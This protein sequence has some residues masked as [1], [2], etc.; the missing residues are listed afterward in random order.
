MFIIYKSNKLDVL[1]SK[2]CQIIQKKPLSN[3]FEKEIFIHDSKILFQYLNVFFAN[4]IGISTN[5]KL[6]HPKNFIWKIFEK[7]LYK[8]K[9]K[10]RFTKSSITWDIMNILNNKNFFKYIRKKDNISKK[11][12]FSYLMANI[13]EKY[14]IYRPNWINEWE[15]NEKRLFIDKNERWQIKLWQEIKNHRKKNHQSIYH[16]SNL[17]NKFQSLE[18]EK[19]IQKKDFPNRFFIISSFALNPSYIKI[20]KI[21]SQYT[22]IYF[23]Y[24]TPFKKNIFHFDLIQN[25]NILSKEKTRKENILNHTI[26]SL[27]GKYEEYYILKI[28]YSKKTKKI[29]Y[30]QKTENT[31]LL[32]NIKNNFLEFNSLKNNK[33]KRK[34]LSLT[35]DSISIN[36]C[37]NIHNEIEI[38]YEKLLIFFNKNKNLKPNDIVV[39]CYSITKYVSSINSIF[40][41]K[42]IKEN[43]PFFISTK[44]SKKT[45]IILLFFNKILDLPNSRFENEEILEFFDIPEV[46]NNFNISEEDINI[47]YYW[48][49]EANIR[50]GIDC[51][52]KKK[53]FF[54]EN[55][56][57]TWSWGI[58]K[59][60]LSYATNHTKGIWN[61]VLSCSIINGSRAELIGKLIIFINTLK[62]WQKK[63]SKL[64]YPSSWRSLFKDLIKD[65][66]EKKNRIT[67]DIQILYKNWIE[68]IDDISSCNYNNKISIKILKKNFTRKINYKNQK[69]LPGVINFCHPYDVCYI[70]FKIIC[71]IGADS[72]N[73]PKKNNVDS[74]INLLHKYPCMGDTDVYEKYCYLFLQSISCT[75]RYFY[76]SYVGYSIK[77]ES[78]IH[79]SIL[80]DQLLNYITLNFFIFNSHRLNIEDN[81][82]KITNHLC[83]T[84]KKQY[85]YRKKKIKNTQDVFKNIIIKK[86][87]N[88]ICNKKLSKNNFFNPITL[89]DLIYFWKNP[90][91]YFFNNYLKIN[92]ISKKEKINNTEP[93]SVKK[94]DSFRIKKILLNKIIKKQDIKEFL[95]YYTLSGKLP[96]GFFG[97]CFLNKIKTEMES[98]AKLVIKYK[99]LTKEKKIDLTLKK[100]RINGVLDEIQ[101]N[102]LLRW[103]PNAI[104]YSDRIGL[105]I[106]H[107]VYSLIEGFG[108]SKIIGYKNQI[109]SFS[110]LDPQTAYNYLYQYIQGYI[111]GSKEIILLTKSGSSWL[112]QVYDIKNNF[113][114]NDDNTKTKGYK[115]LLET[116]IGN[117]YIEGEK[118]DLYVKKT[119]EALDKNN[120]EK[121]CHTAKTWL[122]P[123]LKNKK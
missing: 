53:L 33:T 98:I 46:A 87:K 52:H 66:F 76:V 40:K 114:K 115:K 113:I 82:K 42:N 25:S 102:G 41:S 47:L 34:M 44:F 111:K 36:I 6:Y 65:F 45:E 18:N 50:W 59:L 43:I 119:I 63:T 29:N 105:W 69:F 8:K 72:Q 1:L 54:P 89:K 7:I 97:Q 116:W 10:N 27:W 30:F 91:R 37:Y 35:D 15:K 99:S 122:I 48:I 12:K 21:I 14:L 92:F 93:F 103:K 57:N 20:F 31:N 23:L 96:Y 73:I 77:D 120:I 22:N 123:L 3:I 38:L 68:M 55:K 71:I 32:N 64:K 19:K 67:E 16:F 61:D 117:N 121:I 90:I 26:L 24:L 49:E 75:Q 2:A 100:F 108:E 107:L 74:F 56:E 28:I 60:L 110:P 9:I 5:L 39:T 112:D 11:F 81:K 101:S 88:E 62:K 17:F 85:F 51:K 106:E 4:K 95:Q 104:N 80:I 78:K 58:E 70:P 118:E 83:K 79:P 86:N 84:Y 13:F 94:L 109:W